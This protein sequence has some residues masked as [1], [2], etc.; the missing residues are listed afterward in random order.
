MVNTVKWFRKRPIDIAHLKT[1]PA[2]SGIND[3]SLKILAS[4]G[5]HTPEDIEKFMYG[6]IKDLHDPRKMK[7]AEL[8]VTI[9][10]DSIR[11][12][13]HITVYGD[14]DCD[15][16]G[17]T[18]TMTMLLKEAGAKVSFFT[19]N[20][21]VH[22]YGM[23]PTGV[24]DMLAMYPETKL[25]VTVDNGISAFAGV[26]YAKEKGLKVVVTDHH[27]QGETIPLAD[28]VVNPKRLDC[29]YPFKGLC[30]A[31]VAFKLMLLLYWNMGL[32]LETV[33]K[34]L[35]IVALSTVADVVPLID[36]NR[37]IV[38]KGLE[39][40]SAE[41]RS[42]FRIFR[43]VTEVKV[44][45][46]HYTIGMIY[47]PMVNA[48][49]RLDGDPRR[50]I[51]MFFEDDD[52]KIEDTVRYLREVNERRKQMT[53]E[54]TDIAIAMIEGELDEST[55][56][57]NPGGKGLRYINVVYHP[58]FHEG[59]VGLIA[60]RL[61]ERYNR[62][63]Y[64]FTKEHGFIKGSGRGIDGFHLK[65]AMDKIKYLLKGYGGHAKACGLSLEEENLNPFEEEMNKLAE[66]VLTE[67]DFEKIHRIE[68]VF[69]PNELTVDVV[70]N[71]KE[72]EPFGEAF[73]K[74][75]LAINNFKVEKQFFMGDMKQHVKLK[76]GDLDL[77]MW[78]M[79]E[80]YRKMGEPSVVKAI[81]YPELNVWNN[82]VTVQFVVNDDNLRS[83]S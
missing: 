10:E 66:A 70:E 25:V 75:V 43:S 63:V 45:N 54:Q 42:V 52:Q 11:N 1:H 29:E 60:G 7:D 71:L 32:E 21:F 46:A 30:G 78:S 6:G 19:N 36:E 41:E 5:I 49:G 59:I 17:S 27:D 76:S 79:S 15:G 28:A 58:D 82:K 16:V 61:K 83:A 64:V 74:P 81:G 12:G 13:E 34:T 18:A 24:D 65:Q 2:L 50:A 51:E 77:V 48:I 72:L 35:D 23:C 62:P 44:I 31:G 22:G 56:L 68:L 4:R 40:I 14:Y 57:R 38:A 80:Q 39:K 73:P 20:R 9:I 3:T 69:E 47:A 55:G 33:Y 37:I 8:A 53:V 26:D 67:E